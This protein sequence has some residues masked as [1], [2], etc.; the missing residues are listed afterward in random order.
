MIKYELLFLGLLREKPQ[1]GYEIKRKIKEILRVFAGIDLKS[2]YYPLRVLEKKG[3]VSRHVTKVIRRPQRF[4]YTLTPKGRARFEVLLNRSFLDFKRPQ[5]SL[6]LSL[7]FLKYVTPTVGKRRLRGRIFIL[8]RLSQ[9]LRQMLK[10]EKNLSFSLVLI[11]E[12]NLKML[13]AE[14]QFLKNLIR[15][16]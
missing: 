8:N 6:D 1:H 14:I 10:K 7:Y 13:E 2:I 15:T 12:H 11:I 16:L 4:T 3:L 5:F 9:G